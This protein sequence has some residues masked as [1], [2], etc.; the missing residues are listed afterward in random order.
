MQAL[1][2][3]GLFR[4]EP[5]NLQI[6]NK[7][8][9]VQFLKSE[10]TLNISALTEAVLIR[11]KSGMHRLRLSTPYEQYEF[12]ADDEITAKETVSF[13]MELIENSSGLEIRSIE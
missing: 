9:Q 11:N 8:L 6:K 12:L 1:M 3:T 7:V 2:V 10:R 4:Y 5:C 13:M